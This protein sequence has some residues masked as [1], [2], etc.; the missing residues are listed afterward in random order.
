MQGIWKY[1]TH[2]DPKWSK[3]V[4]DPPQW[5]FGFRPKRSTALP[6]ARRFGRVTRNSGERRLNGLAI[7][8]V[9]KAFDTIRVDSFIYKLA[10]LN[11]LSY[12]LKSFY[13]IYD[14]GRIKR[15]SV[16]PYPQPWHAGWRGTGWI[17]LT[18]CIQSVYQRQV[19]S[20]PH[21]VS[22]L[23]RSRGHYSHLS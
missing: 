14:T 20:R 9:G 17:H 2:Q 4:W 12:L 13:Y 1:P 5:H 7:L 11:L 21:R 3:Q 18:R 23:F 19:Y 22:Y 16:Q 15:L 8:Y 10:V 6:L